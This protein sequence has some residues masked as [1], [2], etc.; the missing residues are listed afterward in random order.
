MQHRRR[1]GKHFFVTVGFLFIETPHRQTNQT[2][3]EIQEKGLRETVVSKATLAAEKA[4]EADQALLGGSLA[5]L[6][7]RGKTAA[8]AGFLALA[9]GRMG[10]SDDS[11]APVFAVLLASTARPKV[12]GASAA[13]AQLFGSAAQ[14]RAVSVASGVAAQ[15]V[16]FAAA[17]QGAEARAA[18]AVAAVAGGEPRPGEIVL[19]VENFIVETAPGTWHDVAHVLLVDKHH[20]ITVRPMGRLA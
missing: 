14:L 9:R 15:P 17:R 18:A 13:L 8:T 4:Q 2:L 19:A 10:A 12:Q 16:G 5:R 1:N 7:A 20:N 3:R 6:V 11:D